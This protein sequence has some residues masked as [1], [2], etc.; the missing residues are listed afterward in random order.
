MSYNEIKL[1]GFGGQGIVLAGAITGQAAA[2]FD[3]KNATL[4]K[5]Y[6]PEARGGACSTQLIIAEDE[7]Y[8]PYVENPNTLVVMSQ[9]AFVKFVP[10][11]QEGGTLIVDEDLVR[12]EDYEAVRDKY[13]LHMIPSTRIA[14]DMGRRI[15]ANIVMLGYFTAV[16][17]LV[18]ADAM[19]SAI[20]KYVPKGTE[21]LNL[22]AFQ[23]GYDH[24]EKPK[25]EE[26]Q[27][28]GKE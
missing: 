26:V 21:E 15:I 11:L 22:D 3:N 16:T 17:G 19:K 7:I 18:S 6:G 12:E 28:G 5:S 10:E 4:V 25:L 8:Y 24:V 14:E 13:G 23:R 2:I 20:K 9:E 27:S 1:A